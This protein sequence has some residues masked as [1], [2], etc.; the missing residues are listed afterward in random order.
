VVDRLEYAGSRQRLIRRLRSHV[1]RRRLRDDVVGRHS[2]NWRPAP[3]E[4]SEARH[5]H[6]QEHYFGWGSRSNRRQGPSTPFCLPGRGSRRR[7]AGRVRKIRARLEPCFIIT[8]TGHAIHFLLH[9]SAG[10]AR[11]NG[12][13]RDLDPAQGPA[14]VVLVSLSCGR[15]PLDRPQRSLTMSQA[16]PIPAADVAFFERSSHPDSV[17]CTSMIA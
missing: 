4:T 9:F 8:S 16:K 15:W 13:L 3:P 14:S 2:R 6:V 11:A 10:P 7:R 17:I 5:L 1:E 12:E